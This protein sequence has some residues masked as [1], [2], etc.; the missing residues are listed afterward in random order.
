LASMIALWPALRCRRRMLLQ[1]FPFV[2]VFFADVGANAP[3]AC[4]FPGSAGRLASS[5]VS[6][7]G[8]ARRLA[9]RRDDEGLLQGRGATVHNTRTDDGDGAQARR[10][11]L[12]G[13]PP[14]CRGWMGAAAAWTA[15]SGWLP[16]ELGSPSSTGAQNDMRYA[17]FPG[18]RRLAIQQ[19]GRVRVYD[20]GEYTISGSPSNR[21]AIR[22]LP[23]RANSGSYASP[24]W[25]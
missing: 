3:E 19:D 12:G 14:R 2:R 7:L 25:L 5:E 1:V 8:G 16:E 22:R 4:Q 6:R 17:C 11:T 24:I 15:A 23:S 9:V 21:A 10:P 20:T 13:K 18:R